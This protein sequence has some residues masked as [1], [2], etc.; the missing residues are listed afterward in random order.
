[1]IEDAKVELIHLEL[2]CEICCDI[3][4]EVVHVHFECPACGDKNAGTSCYGAPWDMLDQA[5]DH[6]SCKE[7]GAD[8]ELVDMG[9]SKWSYDEW[10]WRRV[11]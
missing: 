10:L 3:C 11:K 2:E 5:G 9:S 4:N 7:C 6:L 8:F 1:M